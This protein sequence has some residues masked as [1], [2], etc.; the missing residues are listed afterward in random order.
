MTLSGKILK[1]PSWKKSGQVLDGDIGLLTT[2]VCRYVNILNSN[3]RISSSQLY[4]IRVG[5]TVLITIGAIRRIFIINPN[6]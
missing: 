5:I 4:D 1:F 2:T 3:A 6:A